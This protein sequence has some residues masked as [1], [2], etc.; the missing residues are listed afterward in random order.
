MDSGTAL[1]SEAAESEGRWNKPITPFK[2]PDVHNAINQSFKE[3][4]HGDQTRAELARLGFWTP[5]SL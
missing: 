5:A 2:E 4:V 1:S 3:P